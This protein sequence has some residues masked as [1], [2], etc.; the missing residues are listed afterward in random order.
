MSQ[1]IQ[2]NGIFPAISVP[3]NADYSINEAEF[4]RYV[5][6]IAGFEEF[7]GIV[8]NGHASEITTFSRQERKEMLRIVVDEV[9]GRCPVICAINCEGTLEAIRHISDAEEIGADA[10]LV[11]P[12][13]LWL[14][15]GASKE[16]V[17]AH[18][19]AICESTDLDVAAQVYSAA[20]KAFYPIDTLLGLA[21][22]PNI[23]AFKMAT[24]NSAM[25]E[26]DMRILKEKAPH[27]GRFTCHDDSLL[28]SMHAQ[29]DGA[30]VGF[31]GWAPELVIGAWNAVQSKDYGK[32]KE[33]DELLFHVA[34]VTYGTG[35]PSCDAHARAKE[36]LHQRG[37]FSSGLARLPVMPLSES[38]K[39]DI[40]EAL[41]KSHLK[42]YQF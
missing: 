5:S 36:V 28:T 26:R 29:V 13:H 40:G 17:L 41:K 23:K 3:L 37:F 14:R 35:I 9:G 15:S 31:A 2:W 22:L 27:I 12:S 8:C 20:T 38:A 7:H 21:E 25:F 11:Q 4:R 16:S 24:R 18:F 34:N 39:A 1:K 42:K 10:V 33:Y 6:W 19:R 30:I 32:I